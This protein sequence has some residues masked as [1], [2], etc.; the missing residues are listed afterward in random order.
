MKKAK[1]SQTLNRVPF[2]IIIMVLVTTIF[3]QVLFAEEPSAIVPLQA[4]QFK[5]N[6][7]APGETA[8]EAV[9]LIDKSGLITVEIIATIG[10]L[11][12]NIRGPKGEILNE[13]TINSFG[14]EFSSFAGTQEM[15]SPLILPSSSP[16]FHYIY[17]FPSLGP[18]NYT[19]RFGAPSNLT[20]EVA[21]ITQVIT[22]SSVVAKLIVTEPLLAL[23][24]TAVLVAAVFDGK[25]PVVG[26]NVLV[27]IQ[28]EAGSP[29][30]LTLLDNGHNADTLAGDGLY[31]AEFIPA[32]P[33]KYVAV[34]KIDGL[35]SDSFPFSRQSATQFVVVSPAG[36]L[37]GTMSDKGV[38]DNNN[39]LFDRVTFDVG[40]NTDQ[41]GDFRVFIHLKSAGGQSIVSSTMAN[42]SV[43]IQNIRVDFAAAAFQE[44]KEN[45]PYSIDLV[46]LL[47]LGNEGAMPSDRLIN[48]GQ[49]QAYQ[50]SQF[51]RPPILLAGITGDVGIDTNGN[52]LFDILR[53]DLNVDLLAGGV[54]QWS[55][56]LVD[57]NGKEIDFSGNSGPLNAGVNTITL[58]FDGR[59]I[60]ANGVNG[61]YAVKGFLIFGAGN[62]LIADNVASTRAYNFTAF[63]DAKKLPIIVN[64]LVTF[65]P[66]SSTYQYTS[67]TT[68]C[69]TGYVG[70]YSFKAKLTNTSSNLLSNLAVKVTTLTNNNLLQNADGGPAGAGATL[71]VP[72]LNGYTDGLLSKGE[73]VDIPFVLC[74]KKRTGFSFYVDVWGITQ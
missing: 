33:G 60:G 51:E 1:V 71:T 13:N 11:T 73:Y 31:S 44:L 28:P 22:N 7:L 53:V 69:P 2:W 15:D 47:F 27:T 63:E 66:I 19:V 20:E 36:K 24:N 21:V 40:V 55:A 10:G 32:S 74:L 45:G 57:S 62:S 3:P 65:A 72:K 42:L 54:Y 38:D 4:A 8:N 68:G 30:T 16:G 25:T 14:G 46:E 39:G 59:K 49:T 34:S 56:R 48:S 35:T 58:T 29:I 23:G 43:G 52:G 18:G 61:P 41:A 70:K 64:N 5:L 67:N 37:T 26:A 6:R 12:T 17:T 9:F 50:L